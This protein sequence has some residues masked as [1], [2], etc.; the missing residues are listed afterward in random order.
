MRV[1]RTARTVLGLLVLGAVV[2]AARLVPVE[3]MESTFAF[4]VGYSLCAATVPL[5][6]LLA[7]QE[8][9]PLEE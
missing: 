8:P 2:L 4:A 9:S 7:E 6:A 1:L 3:A 5:L